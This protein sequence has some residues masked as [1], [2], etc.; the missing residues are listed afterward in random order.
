[1]MGAM[2]APWFRCEACVADG[3][4]VRLKQIADG[5]DVPLC[6]G[7]RGPRTRPARL[8]DGRVGPGAAANCVV[9]GGGLGL[10]VGPRRGVG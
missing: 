7:A 10:R 4:K 2:P 5:S 1:M 9:G 8:P 3:W 6:G